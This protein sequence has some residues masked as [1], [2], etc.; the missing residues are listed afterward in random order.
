MHAASAA[1]LRQAEQESDNVSHAARAYPLVVR[2][3]GHCIKDQQLCL[4]MPRYEGS[5]LNLVQ[6]TSLVSSIA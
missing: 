6:G 1:Q 3:L 4:V 5:L 2:V